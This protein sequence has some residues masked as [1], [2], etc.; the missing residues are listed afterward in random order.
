VLPVLSAVQ[1]LTA[2]VLFIIQLL[3]Q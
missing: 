1:V 3:M 2:I